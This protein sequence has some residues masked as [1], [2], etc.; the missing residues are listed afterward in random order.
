MW[1]VIDYSNFEDKKVKTHIIL[2][3]VGNELCGITTESPWGLFRFYNIT[4]RDKF[5]KTFEKQ[6]KICIDYI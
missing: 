6:L 3:N 2:T 5:L 1:N 4:T